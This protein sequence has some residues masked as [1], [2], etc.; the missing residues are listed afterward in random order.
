MS[1]SLL[2][3]T[4]APAKATRLD[5]LVFCGA[6]LVGVVGYFI[7]HRLDVHQLFESGVIVSVMLVYATL[8]ARVPR[9][10]VRMDQAGDNAYYLGLLF[11]LVSMGVALYEFSGTTAD[12]SVGAGRSGAEQ[13]I[14]NFGIAL[15]STIAG[16][17]LRVILHQMRVDPADVESMT[18]I[19][20]SE[21]S[22][23]VKANLDTVSSAL[24]LFQAQSA[25]RMNDIIVSVTGDVTKALA[26]FTAEVGGAASQLLT[27]TQEAQAAITERARVTAQKLDAA[28]EGAHAALER[29][30]NVEA[31]PLKLA[32]SLEKVYASLEQLEKPIEKL[33]S[34]FD[35]TGAASTAVIATIAKATDELV[36]LGRETREH[37]A[38]VLRNI[39][40]AAQ[41][42]RKALEDAGTV[43]YQDRALLRDLEQQAQRA[44]AEAARAREGANAV[45]TTLTETT[46]E[47]TKIVRSGQTSSSGIRTMPTADVVRS[48]PEDDL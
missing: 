1:D 40:D 36:R 48:P 30:S 6:F 20:L 18:R 42:F 31:P 14:A 25:Q 38:L 7:L 16:I 8:V 24:A 9:L 12:T 44:S 35:T 41:G 10:R 28:A 46:R 29:L 23:R 27:Q 22:K 11:T 19:E 45:L 5:V 43:L 13:I 3:E 47:L 17:F 15:A 2:N 34:A 39:L 21:A 33:T 37:Q 4:G 32:T 26:A